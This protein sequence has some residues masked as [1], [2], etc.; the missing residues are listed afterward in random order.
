MVKSPNTI[1]PGMVAIRKPSMKRRVRFPLRGLF[2]GSLCGLELPPSPALI[3]PAPE[4]T[5]GDA[6]EVTRAP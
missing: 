4:A 2:E 1:V 6:L 5:T 3:G